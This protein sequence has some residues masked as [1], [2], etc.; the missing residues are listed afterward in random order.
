MARDEY[1]LA[2]YQ[3]GI[4]LVHQAVASTDPRTWR[5]L[6]SKQMRAQSLAVLKLV[7]NKSR[8]ALYA[9]PID[10]AIVDGRF[11]HREDVIVGF[12]DMEMKVLT[13]AA[14]GRVYPM[15]AH[16]SVSVVPF[17]VPDD[18]EWML[19]ACLHD[20]ERRATA[21]YHITNCRESEWF[22]DTPILSKE[23]MLIQM[24]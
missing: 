10:D 2:D 13:P 19:C 14:S 16:L 23:P 22:A 5:I 8:C 20:Q 24:P 4:K 15:I 12:I 18:A 3:E 9:V 11:A 7:M 1:T 21:L 6:I 17:D